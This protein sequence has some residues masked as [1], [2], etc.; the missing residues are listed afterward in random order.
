MSDVV[1]EGYHVASGNEH[2]HVIHVYGGSVGM[3]R[4]IAERT[5][6]QLLK[7]SETFTAEEVKRFHPCRTRYLALVGGNTSLCAET[8][9]NV[10]STPQERIRSFVREKYAVRLVDVVARRTRVAYS[11]P[12]EAISS[13]PVLAEVMRAELGWS[14]ERVKAELDLARSFICGITTFA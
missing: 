11:S 6:D 8:D 4:L 3:S 13:L 14:P 1:L 7:N 9:V 2:P 12:A 10:A 5:V